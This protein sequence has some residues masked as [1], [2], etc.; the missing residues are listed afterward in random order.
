MRQITVRSIPEELLREIREHA[1]REGVSMNQAVVRLLKR[2]TG[3][4]VAGDRKRR[5]LSRIAG[6][7]T[8]EQAAEFDRVV[9]GFEALD[10]EMWR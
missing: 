7:W 9:E 8:S 6:T 1:R 4:E 10:E 5:D 2:A 3:L